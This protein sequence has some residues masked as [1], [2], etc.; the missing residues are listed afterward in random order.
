[1]AKTAQNDGLLLN[2]AV[3]YSARAELRAAVTRVASDVAAGTLA[4]GAI[5]E[6]LIAS[7]L[8]TAGLPD[9]ELLIRPGGES[10]LSNFLLYQLAG[11][12]LYLT[13]T[14]WPDFSREH[15]AA[16]LADYRSRVAAAPAGSS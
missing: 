9:P 1:M 13:D 6:E 3:N 15:F 4:P 11:A 14:Y 2:L 12:E 10:R 5:D 16:A 8:F 7:Y